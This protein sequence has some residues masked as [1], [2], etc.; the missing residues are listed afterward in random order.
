MT[1]QKTLVRMGIFLGALLLSL[2]GFANAQTSSSGSGTVTFTVT[3]VGKKQEAPPIAKDDVQLSQGKERKQIADW[4][5]GEELY[6]AILID[7]AIDQNSGGQW[8]YLK[9]FISAQP[10]NTFIALG[11]LQNNTTLVAQDFTQNKELVNKALRIPIGT[12]ALGSSPY[13][14]IIDMLKRWPNTGP[15][16]SIV[17][18][19]SGID[20][21]RGPGSGP[22]YP[23]VDPLIQRAERQNTNIWSIYYP[24]SGHR[25]RAFFLV[26]TAQINIDKVSE[27]TGAESYFLGYGTPVSIKP[28][29]DE[30]STHLNNQ[31]LLTFAGSGGSKGKFQSIKVKTELPDVEFMAPSAVFLPPGS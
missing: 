27:E 20:Y 5:K 17:V 23:D 11:Y 8:D 10:A 29:L 16:R 1:Y 25:G 28:Y 24:S 21:F 22:I 31:Y 2:T 3:A 4:K 13:L 30:I 14:S 26:N 7:S 19:T 18:I 6:L 15:R 9:E 12:A